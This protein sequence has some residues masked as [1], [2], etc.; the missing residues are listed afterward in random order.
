MHSYSVGGGQPAPLAL[1]I[2]DTLRERYFHPDTYHLP[3]TAR[4]IAQWTPNGAERIEDVEWALADLRKRGWVE[5]QQAQYIG[6][7]WTL[8]ARGLAEGIRRREN[9]NRSKAILTARVRAAT[10]SH[11]RPAG[12]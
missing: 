7:V 5:A 6:K 11:E 4:A 12:R 8:T 3:L 1:A 9:A 2:V 10:V